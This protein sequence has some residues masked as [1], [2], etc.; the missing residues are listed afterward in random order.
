M[1]ASA[2]QG[3]HNKAIKQCNIQNTLMLGTIYDIANIQHQPKVIKIQT[4]VVARN[5]NQFTVPRQS[6]NA[7]NF[8]SCSQI[9]HRT[10]ILKLSSSSQV[11]FSLLQGSA[12]SNYF[13]NYTN[14]VPDFKLYYTQDAS[15]M[16]YITDIIHNIEKV[17]SPY[18]L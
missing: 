11:Q 4:T 7:F 1:S 2:M 12:I 16:N 13:I 8:R 17:A 5:V 10:A 14:L 15:E 6:H 18:T 9:N 3:G